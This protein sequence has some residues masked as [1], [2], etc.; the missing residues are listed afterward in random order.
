MRRSGSVG[1][2]RCGRALAASTVADLVVA[3]GATLVEIPAPSPI[4]K[5]P[6]WVVTHRDLR[7]ARPLQIVREWIVGAFRAA[8]AA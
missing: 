5:R 4:P 2:V 7:H 8:Q 3:R 6:A 1:H